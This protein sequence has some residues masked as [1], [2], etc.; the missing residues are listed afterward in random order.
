MFRPSRDKGYLAEAGDI[1]V[2][3]RYN[4]YGRYWIAAE[5]GVTELKDTSYKGLYKQMVKKYNAHFQVREA[6][7]PKEAND[8]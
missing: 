4:H 2:V 3:I 1:T 6:G 5:G 7:T 8:D